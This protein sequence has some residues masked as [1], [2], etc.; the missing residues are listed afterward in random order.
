MRIFF[1]PTSFIILICLL[2]FFIEGCTFFADPADVGDAAPCNNESWIPPYKIKREERYCEE[3]LPEKTPVSVAELIDY[4]LRNN[5][6]TKVT[7]NT[8][9]A[10]AYIL[11]ANYNTFYP[12]VTATEEIEFVKSHFNAGTGGARNAAG[13]IINGAA[14]INNVNDTNGTINTGGGGVIIGGGGGGGGAGTNS[15]GAV[16]N[17]FLITDLSVSYIML[18]FGGRQASVEA[19]RQA[20]FS[21]NWTHNRNLQTVI[22]TI[23]QSYYNYIAAEA[24]VEAQKENFNNAKQNLE[25]AKTM[26][27]AGV[28]RLV[29]FLLARS[30]FVNAELLLEQAYNNLHTTMGQLATAIGIPADRKFDVVPMP[31]KLPEVNIE[32]DMHAL[33]EKAKDLRP[34]LAATYSN[35]L[36]A[37]EQITIQ[38]SAGMPIVSAFA[39]YELAQITAKR[40][41]ILAE[42]DFI[43]KLNYEQYQSNVKAAEGQVLN[44]QAAVELAQINLGWST[45]LAPID[46]KISQFNIDPGNLVVA[47]DANAL[48]DLRSITP[49]DIRFYVNQTDYMKVQRAMKEGQLKFEVYMPQ[50]PTHIRQGKIYFYDNHLDLNTGTILIKGSVPNQDE[51][52]WPG[53]FVRVRLQLRVQPQALLIPEEAIQYGQDG[54]FVYVY[55]VDTSIVEYRP[56]VKGEK[57]GKMF[58]IEKGVNPGEQV[59]TKGQGN[60]RPNAK[61]YLVGAKKE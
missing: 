52:F 56:V 57:V 19:A 17:Q 23:L 41:A 55:K 4:G 30:A 29:D 58:L 28:A 60:L 25:S 33:L 46:G 18:D 45:V 48:T 6:Q 11:Y 9:R 40:Y 37:I 50:I 43:S 49:A 7:W 12:H 47:N 51:Y 36:N 8:A 54:S 20:L 21:A 13:N 38:Y 42:K 35:Y 39:D 22:L 44:D 5:P 27:E 31:E 61:V 24:T 32:K 1:Y 10:N 34:D 3:E 15:V 59:V 16:Y 26:Y 2:V 53:E 14:A